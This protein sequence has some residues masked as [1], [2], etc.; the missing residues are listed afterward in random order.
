MQSGREKDMTDY[1]QSGD[2]SG[3]TSG[4]LLGLI[5]G[6]AGGYLL[7]TEKGQELIDQIKENGGEKVKEIMTNPMIADKLADLEKTMAQARAT[8]QNTQGDAQAKVHEVATQ[9]AEATAPPQPKK[10]FFQ[11]HGMTL[12]K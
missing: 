5:V 11:R 4:F 6:G 12:K 9:I 8:L 1:Q 7:S 3:F 2:A 10:N